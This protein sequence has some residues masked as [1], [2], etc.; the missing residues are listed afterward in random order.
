MNEDIRI[1]FDD[2]LESSDLAVG[3]GS[4]K[5][6]IDMFNPQLIIYGFEN[7]FLSFCYD[8]LT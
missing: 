1:I 6:S 4:G 3:L 8:L 7:R 5:P 2:L